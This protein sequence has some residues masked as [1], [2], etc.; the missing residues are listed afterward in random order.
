VGKEEEEE[1]GSGKRL[2]SGSAH[3][4]P[5][6]KPDFDPIKAFEPA[7]IDQSLNIKARIHGGLWRTLSE[8]H[9][10]TPPARF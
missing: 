8:M 7:P 3:C 10:T 2:D 4:A 9:E 1:R 5:V 6:D